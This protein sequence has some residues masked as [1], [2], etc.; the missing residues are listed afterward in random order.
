MSTTSARS[1]QAALI[2]LL[3]LAAAACNAGSGESSGEDV[4]LVRVIDGDTIVVTID[5]VEER[6][7]Y[8][9]IDSP[10]FADDEPAA[11][12]AT[13]ANAALVEDAEIELERDVSDRDRF[14]RLLRYVWVGD[15]LVNEELVRQGR[16]DA[17]AYEPDV[18]HQ[19]RLFEAEEEARDE[20]LGIWADE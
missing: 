3:A 8:I 13:D 15:T 18:K 10:E 2:S 19:E 1:F 6:V 5:G 20:G 14:G 9:G 12:R 16:A 7:R 11:Q 4:D 17:I